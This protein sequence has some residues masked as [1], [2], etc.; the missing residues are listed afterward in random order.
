MTPQEEA[1]SAPDQEETNES[2]S[3]TDPALQRALLKVGLAVLM[4]Y[5]VVDTMSNWRHARQQDARAFEELIDQTALVNLPPSLNAGL[6]ERAT[7]AAR[8]YHYDDLDNGAAERVLGEHKDAFDTALADL[9]AA[10]DRYDEA[11]TVPGEGHIDDIVQSAERDA[12]NAAEEVGRMAERLSEYPV[13]EVMPWKRM[14]NDPAT[15]RPSYFALDVATKREVVLVAD[16]VDRLGISYRYHIE[17]R[18][19]EEYVLTHASAYRSFETTEWMRTLIVR[20]TPGGTAEGQRMANQIAR[21]AAT[22]GGQ[23]REMADRNRSPW[24]RAGTDALRR[25][26][27]AYARAQN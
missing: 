8:N 18:G 21:D 24:M 7:E 5:G 15:G 3:R 11:M 16:D 14:G 20:G 6:L 27:D 19:E 26:A 25:M 9:L 13:R 23:A 4:L 1:G 10:R 2:A 12:A 22:M 17:D